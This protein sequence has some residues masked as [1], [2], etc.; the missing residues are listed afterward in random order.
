M[1]KQFGKLQQIDIFQIRDDFPFPLLPLLHHLLHQCSNGI[2][3]N[4]FA[5]D[6]D[7]DLMITIYVCLLSEI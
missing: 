6:D 7:F 5:N 3:D 2:E 1:H 4:Y